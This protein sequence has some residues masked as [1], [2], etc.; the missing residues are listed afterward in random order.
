MCEKHD[1]DPEDQLW[2]IEDYPRNSLIRVDGVGAS[3]LML[4]RPAMLRMLDEYGD[5]AFPWFE[6]IK[7]N[8]VVY[9]EDLGLSIKASAI[10]LPIYVN[11]AAKVGH[12]KPLVLN[13]TMYNRQL[14]TIPAGHDHIRNDGV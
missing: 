6:E 3:C 5:R 7:H 2:L 14:L 1:D 8:G 12:Y 4:H 13:E 11:T 9:G 10:G